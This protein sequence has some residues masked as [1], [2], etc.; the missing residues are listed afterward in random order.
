V[1]G[2]SSQDGAP[3][4]AASTAVAVVSP[5]VTQPRLSIQNAGDTFILEWPA[6]TAPGFVLETTTNLAF[7]GP[8]LV[9]S[10]AA[11]P[12]LIPKTPA[13]CTRFYRIRMP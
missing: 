11:S 3:V 4:V 1:A 13:N 9:I 12:F 5:A 7:P 10:N 2:Q 6:A 8:W